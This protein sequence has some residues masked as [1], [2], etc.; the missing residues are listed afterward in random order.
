MTLHIGF[1]FDGVLAGDSGE[2]VNQSHGYR[3][4]HKHE[5]INE[6]DLI[7]DG[8]LIK[9]FEILMRFRKDH[10][11]SLKIS[12]VSA[13]S[14]TASKRVFELLKFYGCSEVDNMVF[15]AGGPKK[16]IIEALELDLFFDDKLEHVNN[17]E[18]TIGVHVLYGVCNGGRGTTR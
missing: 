15:T 2:Y 16:A 11:E 1:D 10:P 12:I 17:L 18:G 9:L 13:R 3:A 7:E 6:T 4:F 8:P 5:G 14:F